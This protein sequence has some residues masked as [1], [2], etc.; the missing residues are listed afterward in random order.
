MDMVILG[1]SNCYCVGVRGVK[2]EVGGGE[3]RGRVVKGEGGKRTL[4][5]C[6]AIEGISSRT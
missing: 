1:A 4:W 3:S 5:G 2:G 6:I